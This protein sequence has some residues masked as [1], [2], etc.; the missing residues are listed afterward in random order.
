[1]LKQ[2]WLRVAFVT[3]LGVALPG[4][5]NVKA[6]VY[7]NGVVTKQVRAV[8]ESAYE[9]AAW[10]AVK[11][12]LS[13][14][15]GW[16]LEKCRQGGN[17]I[18][19]AEQYIAAGSL[20]PGTH[21]RLKTTDLLHRSYDYEEQFVLAKYATSAAAQAVAAAIPVVVSVRMPGKILQAPGASV[22]QNVATWNLD[23]TAE[24]AAVRATSY[25]TRYCMAAWTLIVALLALATIIAWLREKVTGRG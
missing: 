19:L 4:C 20:A 10:Q 13:P 21:L 16:H 9:D 23:L 6:T 25:Q 15:Q 2:T 11:Q 18:I 12:N 3:C 22:Y 17:T 14:H 24:G 5:V 1:M 8:V 7:S